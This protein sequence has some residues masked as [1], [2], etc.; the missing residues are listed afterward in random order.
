MFLGPDG[1]PLP[2]TQA[3]DVGFSVGTP[4]VLRLLA[5]DPPV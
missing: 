2:F 1:K 5:L 3:M 4:G